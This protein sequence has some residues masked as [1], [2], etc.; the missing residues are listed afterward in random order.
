MKNSSFPKRR[1][2]FKQY[3]TLALSFPVISSLARA[4]SSER[5][6]V[7]K[8]NPLPADT[9]FQF[10]GAAHGNFVKVKEML[11]REPALVNACWDWGGGDFEVALGGAA[12]MG[13]RDIVNYLLDNNARIDVFCAAMLG[14]KG[15]IESLLKSKP[16][17]ANVRGPH[18]Y[19][20]LYH[21]A[22]SGDVSMAEAI[23][24]H[25]DKDK[26]S[27]D[28]NRSLQAAARD[29]HAPMIEW[30]FS[31]GAQNTDTK[32]V[33][34]KSPLQLAEERGHKEAAMVLKKY[35]AK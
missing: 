3:L 34:G 1:K 23:R 13:N 7:N 8:S 4:S 31:N 22:I 15:I 28:C 35:G 5:G 27:N 2:F 10:V 17:I 25:I 16:G 24:P 12:H 19:P 6:D 20:L 21:A 32:D 33:L 9:V 30:L 14:E 26:I 11:A 18:K 29:G